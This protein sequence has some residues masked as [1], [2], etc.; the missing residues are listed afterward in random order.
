MSKHNNDDL[1]KS[2]FDKQTKII[3]LIVTK[4]KYTWIV[5]GIYTVFNY[6][7]SNIGWVSNWPVTI[8]RPP[9]NIVMSV[10]LIILPNKN[11]RKYLH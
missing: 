6:L 3:W 9:C 1:S 11:L 5:I 7:N 10:Y 8:N 2:I 4:Q